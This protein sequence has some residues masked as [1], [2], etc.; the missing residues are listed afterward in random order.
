MSDTTKS[1]LQDIVQT[2]KQIDQI[3][4]EKASAKQSEAEKAQ[5]KRN[6]AKKYWE[7]ALE[8]IDAAIAFVNAEIAEAGLS[9][10]AATTER[11]P[12]PAL[13]QY[14]IKLLEGTEDTK[15]GVIL[16]V[17]ALGLV[18]AV[19]HIPHT[20]RAPKHFELQDAGTD[21]YKDMIV[22]C[23]EQVLTYRKSKL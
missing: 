19:I 5:T 20:G 3:V 16:N 8:Q 6:L 18:Q 11:N 15:C 4:Q 17:S 1:R 2:K 12:S 10:S 13:A 14:Y 7:T 9:L 21:T 23:I 22:D